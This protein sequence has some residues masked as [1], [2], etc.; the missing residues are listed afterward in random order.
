LHNQQTKKNVPVQERSSKRRRRNDK[1]TEGRAA[2]AAAATLIDMEAAGAQVEGPAAGDGLFN[3]M[4][5]MFGLGT[6]R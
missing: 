5:G 6:R 2:G 1:R 4:L 3:G